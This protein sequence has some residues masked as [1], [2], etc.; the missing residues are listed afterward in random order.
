[1]SSTAYCHFEELFVEPLRNGL[2][3]PRSVRGSGTKMVNMGE[4]F[5][6]SRLGDIQMDRVPL[7]ASQ[8]GESRCTHGARG[9]LAT[10]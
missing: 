1:M 6:H 8:L 7:G 4:I 2:T 3:R 5:A 10:R 9:E